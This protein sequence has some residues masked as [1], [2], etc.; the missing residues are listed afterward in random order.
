MKYIIF[1]TKW[2]YF[3]LAGTEKAVC[4]TI[5]PLEKEES[6]KSLILKE[7]PDAQL[8]KNL[9][10]NLQQKII[11][12]FEGKNVD[13]STDIPVYLN[14]SGEFSHKIL[15]TCRTITYGQTTTYADLA[16]KA[17]HPGAARAVGSVMAQNP[18]PLIIPCHRIIRTDGQMGGFS[19]PG[20]INLKKRM[21]SLEKQT[22][23]S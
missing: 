7:F 23:K 12:Y 20:G 5:L 11:A 2:G 1:Q 18:I 4:R 17:K 14:G 3:G 21:L 22:F 13:F 10:K 15:N 9:F 16:Q 19:A 8:D 6:V